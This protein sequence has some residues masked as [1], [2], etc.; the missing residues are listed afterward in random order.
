LPNKPEVSAPHLATNAREIDSEA[1]PFPPPGPADLEI[2]W[3]FTLSESD[4]GDHSSFAMLLVPTRSDT[5]EDRAEASHARRLILRR[6]RAIGL[7]DAGVL[8]AAYT[9]RPWSLALREELGRVTGVMVRL[10][11]AEDGLPDDDAELDALE[12]RAADRLTEALARD[13]RA[14]LARLHARGLALL[15]RAFRAY[16][17]E[18]GGARVD[19]LRGV[20]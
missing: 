6:L 10:A 11:A 13:G 12:R 4:M 20:R 1:L 3:F 17:R 8:Q 19:A 5:P 18:R 15:R 2:E 7:H 16:V 14:S 9:P